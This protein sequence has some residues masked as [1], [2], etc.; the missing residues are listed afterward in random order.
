MA[1]MAHREFSVDIKV[2][3]TVSPALQRT[4][5]MSRLSAARVPLP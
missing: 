3:V 1:C 2:A 4:K 5:E